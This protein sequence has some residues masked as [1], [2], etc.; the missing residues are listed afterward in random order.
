MREIRRKTRTRGGMRD[1]DDG[2]PRWTLRGST[3]ILLDIAKKYEK[4]PKNGPM[5]DWGDVYLGKS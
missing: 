2:V 1:W 5:R 3:K 4:N